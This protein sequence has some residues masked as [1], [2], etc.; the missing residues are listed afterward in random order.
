MQ[1]F[2][3]YS[4]KGIGGGHRRHIGGVPEEG[5]DLLAV[6][7]LHEPGRVQEAPFGQQAGARPVF[8]RAEHFLQPGIGGKEGMAAE[9]RIGAAPQ[10]V[11]QAFRSVQGGTMA[12]QNTLERSR[13]KQHAHGV[14]VHLASPDGSKGRLRRRFRRCLIK[15]KPAA[16]KG[17][18]LQHR[19][20]L[21]VAEDDP[22]PDL[23]QNRP[24]PAGGHFRIQGN[25]IAPGIHS[26]QHSRRGGGSAAHE[27]CHRFPADSPAVQVISHRP[28]LLIQPGEGHFLT[29][30][31]ERPLLRQPGYGFFQIFQN[32]GHH[33]QFPLSLVSWERHAL[34]LLP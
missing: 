14:R 25:K 21:F 15:S 31:P 34:C 26:A 2:W 28:G 13:R 29:G 30:I 24:D 18:I 1:I 22:R 11:P 19:V 7:V 32:V 9:H 17:R 3:R 20:G 6:H 33:S 10:Q 8:H 5:I 16:G 27:H 4:G 23:F 12:D